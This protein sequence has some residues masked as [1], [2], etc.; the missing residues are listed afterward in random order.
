MQIGNQQYPFK[1]LSKYAF[2]DKD[3]SLATK[4]FGFCDAYGAWVV[5]QMTENAIRYS[6]GRTA[7]QTNWSNR[8]SLVYKNLNEINLY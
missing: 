1:D 6:S 5:M 3:D 7:Y 2:H 4:Y 8:V